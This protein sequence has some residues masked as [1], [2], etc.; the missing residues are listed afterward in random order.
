M[1]SCELYHSGLELN[2]CLYAGPGA[3]GFTYGVGMHAT[4]SMQGTVLVLR[5]SWSLC[6]RFVIHAFS[7]LDMKPG[8]LIRASDK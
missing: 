7:L 5:K 4:R 2:S 3:W 6:E 1:R 8:C